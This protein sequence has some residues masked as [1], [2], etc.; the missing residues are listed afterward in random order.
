VLLTD[1]VM[2]AMSGTELVEQIRPIRPDARVLFMSGYSRG[3]LSPQRALD[4]DVA[5]IQKPFSEDMLI[6]RLLSLGDDH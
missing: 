6:E 5:L 3:V 1:V 2:P 4:D